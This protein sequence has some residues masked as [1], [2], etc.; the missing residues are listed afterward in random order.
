MH[1]TTRLPS[2]KEV[3]VLRLLRDGPAEMYG[4]E[5]VKASDGDLGRAAIYITLD[6]M[7]GK[8]YIKRRIPASDTHS[9]LPRPRYKLT[10]LGERALEAVEAA[11]EVLGTAMMRAPA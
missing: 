10:A 3:L 5:I 4:L 9:G 1:M 7:E 8:G 11:Q 2:G 6:R